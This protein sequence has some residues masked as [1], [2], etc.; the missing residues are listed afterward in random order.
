VRAEIRKAAVGRRTTAPAANASP[1]GTLKP[2]ERALIWGLFHRTGETLAALA[3]LE[4]ADYDQLA[5]RAIFE[6]ALGLQ[7]R[8]GQAVPSE[9]LRRLST[10]DA[11][12]VTGI[13]GQA[14]A[15]ATGLD[16]CARS[17]KRLRWERERAA[18]QREIDRLQDQGSARDGDRIDL[19]LNQKHSL[20]LRIK[21]L[22]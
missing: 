10:M 11:Q 6:A 18:I 13:A 17:L 4:P 12:L 7:D 5:G 9:L 14:A 1:A 3:A 16:E 15:P 19:L 8:P 2:A 20:S 21:E 22:T